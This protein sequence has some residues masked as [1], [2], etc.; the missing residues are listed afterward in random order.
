LIG[1]ANIAPNL[2][3][4]GVK[5]RER[6][7]IYQPLRV[8]NQNRTNDSRV[9]EDD[10]KCV[11]VNPK[12]KGTRKIIRAG[13]LVKNNIHPSHKGRNIVPHQNE[14][15][16]NSFIE[17]KSFNSTNSK[18]TPMVEKVPGKELNQTINNEY[19]DGETTKT[20]VRDLERNSKILDFQNKI[21]SSASIGPYPI[22]NSFDPNVTMKTIAQANENLDKKLK[23]KQYVR[24]LEEQIKLRDK[25]RREEESMKSNRLPS[26]E[27]MSA[28]IK[29][30][31]QELQFEQVQIEPVSSPPK[32]VVESKDK[33]A[34][35]SAPKIAGSVIIS[36]VSDPF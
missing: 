3:V 15:F 12:R 8:I 11:K 28:D 6:S 17:G 13:S 24:E 20:N 33:R 1:N 34:L 31:S 27:P 23:Q 21:I 30:A 29:E 14:D 2:H 19:E 35:G 32:T 25:I 16:S 18:K 4:G 5:M 10:E 26:Q 9:Y 36:E 22:S 7:K